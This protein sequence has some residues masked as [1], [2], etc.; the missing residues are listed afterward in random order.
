VSTEG[1]A[2]RDGGW[3][4]GR[5]Q[6][7]LEI[8]ICEPPGSPAQWCCQ[9]TTVTQ[10]LGAAVCLFLRYWLGF[11]IPATEQIRPATIRSR[12]RGPLQGLDCVQESIW[13]F[14]ISVFF[15]SETPG[16]R[17]GLFQMSGAV[18][19]AFRRHLRHE[20]RFGTPGSG[21]SP[22]LAQEGENDEGDGINVT[23]KRYGLGGRK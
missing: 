20:R 18:R 16:G 21:T 7:E 14:T 1:T 12:S 15:S 8:G 2:V 5:K 6:E 17:F 19:G 23:R 3:K 9:R 11:V 10:P 4:L 13:I 22:P